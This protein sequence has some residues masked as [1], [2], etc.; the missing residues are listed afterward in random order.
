MNNDS[1]ML[2]HL[3]YVSKVGVEDLTHAEYDTLRTLAE[4]YLMR[5]AEAEHNQRKREQY[6]KR[7]QTIAA[8]IGQQQ[9]LQKI[10]DELQQ[11]MSDLQD[12]LRS[13]Q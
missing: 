8:A 12:Q 10:V 7:K 3:D 1:P 13:L 6:K 2:N 11:S 9:K 4:K 5:C